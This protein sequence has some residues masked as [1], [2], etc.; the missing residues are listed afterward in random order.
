MPMP[1]SQPRELLGWAGQPR[2]CPARIAGPEQTCAQSRTVAAAKS[3][4]RPKIYE[5]PQQHRG[6]TM[7]PRGHRRR[8]PRHAQ[9]RRGRFTRTRE[10]CSRPH[11]RR[12]CQSSPVRPLPD[13]RPG[14]DGHGSPA[15]LPRP[16][17]SLRFLPDRQKETRAPPRKPQRFQQ[18]RPCQCGHCRWHQRR[19][20]TPPRRPPCRFDPL[21]PPVV[22]FRYGAGWPPRPRGLPC[23]IPAFAA[24]PPWAPSPAPPPPP[25]PRRCPP[26]QTAAEQTTPMLPR[27]SHPC[28]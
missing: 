2:Y 9:E 12:R 10:R 3:T 21:L 15:A 5:P 8:L 26:P 13:A 20:P 16:E 14:S 22:P 23:R 28:G 24:P 27:R 6:C 19:P 17:T 18:W 11:R 7:L 1:P 4:Q 25:L